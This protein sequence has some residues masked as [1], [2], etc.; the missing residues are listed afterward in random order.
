MKQPYGFEELAARDLLLKLT[1]PRPVDD[2]NGRPLTVVTV[3]P[4]PM[5][6]NGLDCCATVKTIVAVKLDR[7]K[8]R[9]LRTTR[10]GHAHCSDVCVNGH[11]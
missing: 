10:F 9:P 2:R 3:T 8:I 7:L 11:V 4:F 6:L 5:S 1:F